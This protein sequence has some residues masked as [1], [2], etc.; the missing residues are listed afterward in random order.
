MIAIAT[1]VP[2][3]TDVG[4]GQGSLSRVWVDR[5]EI[6]EVRM[7]GGIGTAQGQ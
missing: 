1:Q 7:V 2:G 6:A 3:A 5:A 4:R